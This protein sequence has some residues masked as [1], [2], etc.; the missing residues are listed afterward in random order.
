MLPCRMKA[1]AVVMPFLNL[2]AAYTVLLMQSVEDV[3]TE[4]VFTA[5]D[6]DGNARVDLRELAT[7]LS[8][9][10]APSVCSFVVKLKRM[11]LHYQTFHGIQHCHRCWS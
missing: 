1:H 10:G 4:G 3:D 5:A 7:A 8:K 9:S 2:H 11:S 6:A